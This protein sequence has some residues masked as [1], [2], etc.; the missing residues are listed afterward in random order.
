MNKTKPL[1]K[2]K[3]IFRYD[4]RQNDFIASSPTDMHDGRLL[5]GMF[6]GNTDSL[7]QRLEDRGFDTKTVRF[8]IKLSDKQ[9]IVNAL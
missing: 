3:L 8:E 1:S 2:D 5:M 4:K 7:L 9:R 6:C